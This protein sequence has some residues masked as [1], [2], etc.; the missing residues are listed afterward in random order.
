MQL[1]PQLGKSC[2]SEGLSQITTESDCQAAAIELGLTWGSSWNGGNEMPGC[3]YAEDSRKKVYFN[4]SPNAGWDN[5][6]NKAHYKSICKGNLWLYD[7]Y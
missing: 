3:V 1:L 5:P 4:T 7:F 6:Y 2:S